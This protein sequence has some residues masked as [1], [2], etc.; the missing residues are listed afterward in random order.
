MLISIY[1]YNYI[2]YVST[3]HIYTIR[4][5]HIYWDWNWNIYFVKRGIS[6]HQNES[7]PST[8]LLDAIFSAMFTFISVSWGWN[9]NRSPQDESQSLIRNINTKGYVLYGLQHK[10]D[11]TSPGCWWCYWCSG[12]TTVTIQKYPNTNIVTGYC[13]IVFETSY[14][15]VGGTMNYLPINQCHILRHKCV[16][17]PWSF[18]SLQ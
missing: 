15:L 16:F 8:D 3:I 11:L 17:D 18:N 5:H 12:C 10:F 9:P 6:K 4:M 14:I 7:F 2:P 1:I 13:C